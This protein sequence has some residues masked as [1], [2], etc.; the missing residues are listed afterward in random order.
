MCAA[1]SFIE[2]RRT[3]HHQLLA[4]PEALRVDGCLAAD[5]AHGG[6]LGDGVGDGHEL[7]DRA[8]RLPGERSIEPGH[9]DALAAV[10]EVIGQSEHLRAE[11]LHLVH[12]KHVHAVE[13]WF[14]GLPQPLYRGYSD[15]LM[16]L[17]TVRR[18]GRPVIAEVDVRLEAEHA[19]ASDT[20]PTQAPDQLFR[21]AGEHGTGDDF[22]GTGSKGDGHSVDR[23]SITGVDIWRILARYSEDSSMRF[24]WL[25]AATV[26]LTFTAQA[27]APAG[28]LA[29]GSDEIK[30]TLQDAHGATVGTVSFRTVKKGVK[31]KIMLEGLPFGPHGVHIHQNA[32]CEAPDF[33]SAGPHFNPD[34][35][36]HG[37]MNAMGHHNGDMP[38]S[39]SIGEDHRGEASFVLESISLDPAAANSLFLNGG[40]SVVVHEKADD[41]TTDPSGASGNR[42]ACGVIKP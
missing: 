12:A 15:S 20:G 9:N 1:A 24:G 28:A 7:R 25:A 21:F 41:E 38:A 39:V 6:E 35:K 32:V 14:Q 13:L 29:A 37:Y 11:E 22:E 31:V 19:L 33:K 2:A 42:I 8:E 26:A 27:T 10:D 5:H 30:V 16:G 18:D 40:T 17:R 23:I 4:L 34:G 36:Q 3:H